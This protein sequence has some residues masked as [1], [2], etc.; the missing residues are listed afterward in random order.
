MLLSTSLELK[1]AVFI[2]RL[3]SF[4]VLFGVWLLHVL[5]AI[6]CDVCTGHEGRLVGAEIDN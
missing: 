4:L 3:L 6:N 1:A 5:A 2:W